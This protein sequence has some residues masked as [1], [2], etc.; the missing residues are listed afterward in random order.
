MSISK[1]VL[2]VK[3][4]LLSDVASLKNQPSFCASFSEDFLTAVI[5]LSVLCFC[6]SVCVY[7]VAMYTR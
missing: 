2:F 6:V 4:K 1:L 7:A 5:R 3:D